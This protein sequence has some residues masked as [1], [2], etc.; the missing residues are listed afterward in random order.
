MFI[1]GHEMKCL[2]PEPPELFWFVPGGWCEQLG[3][4]DRESPGRRGQLPHHPSRAGL[5][6]EGLLGFVLLYFCSSPGGKPG[7]SSSYLWEAT[8]MESKLKSP[9]MVSFCQNPDMGGDDAARLGGAGRGK[10]HP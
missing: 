2:S 1:G 9:Q 4:G 10:K 8:V 7:I 3:A 6:V 5:P